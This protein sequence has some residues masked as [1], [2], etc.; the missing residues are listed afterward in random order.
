MH[1]SHLTYYSYYGMI[2][3]MNDKKIVTNLRIGEQQWLQVKAI[4]AESGMSVN[5]YVNA[6]ITRLTTA[7][8]L[9]I[10]DKKPKPGKAPIWSIGEIVAGKG[11][12]LSAEDEEI[13][14]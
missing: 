5:E 4:A 13:Y 7:Q 3:T 11:K 6:L 10:T 9:G 8:E 2:H 14:A 12:G 1:N